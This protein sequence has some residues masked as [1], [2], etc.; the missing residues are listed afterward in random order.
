MGRGTARYPVWAGEGGGS[1]PRVYWTGFDGSC[2]ERAL[3]VAASETI[4]PRITSSVNN[5]HSAT[6]N[7]QTPKVDRK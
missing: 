4:A 7:L 5:A 6:L 2:P 3:P 1:K